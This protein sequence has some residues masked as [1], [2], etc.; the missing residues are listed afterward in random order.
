[1]EMGAAVRN[2]SVCYGATTA[3]A[4]VDLEVRAGEVHAV[5]GENGAGKS[6]LLRA[7]AGAVRPSAG[8]VVGA[9]GV[10]WVPQETLLPPDLTAAEW[11]F[12]GVELCG[13]LGWL[14]RTAMR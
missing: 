4:G 1:M 5:V 2:L 11:I 14:R 8:Q 12:L 6:T 3:L 9:T 7:L 10:A 13:P